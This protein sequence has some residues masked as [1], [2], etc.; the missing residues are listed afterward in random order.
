MQMSGK[1]L[2]VLHDLSI[3][4]NGN[5]DQILASLN[6]DQFPLPLTFKV[7][8]AMDVFKNDLNRL[9]IGADAVHPNNNAESVNIGGEY[10]FKDAFA[11]RAGYKSVFLERTVEGLSLG[12]GFKYD[13]YSGLGLQLD[14]AYQKFRNTVLDVYP[15]L[16]NQHKILVLSLSF[17]VNC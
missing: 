2:E 15:A 6:T 17:I 7:G 13:L 11:L 4:N 5:N 8:V 10:V 1:D 16:I 3:N 9:S 14:Y 12:A